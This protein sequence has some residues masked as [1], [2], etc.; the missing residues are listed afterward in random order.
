MIALGLGIGAGVVLALAMVRFW[1]GPTLYDRA[2]A[3]SLIVIACAVV[4]AA[5]A[6]H[7]AQAAWIDASLALVFGAL[8]FNAAVLKF[9]RSRT[10]Q[11]PL[12]R[13]HKGVS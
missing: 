13:E 5:F 3:A 8:V 9:F 11:P 12:A 1:I 7:E 6:V 4:C 2:L 10:Y